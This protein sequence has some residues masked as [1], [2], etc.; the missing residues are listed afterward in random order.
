V[1]VARAR[2]TGGQDLATWNAGSPS[3]LEASEIRKLAYFCRV[4]GCPLYVVHLNS[5]QGLDAVRQARAEGTRIIAETCPQYLVHSFAEE[6]DNVLLKHTPPLR[7]P[8][9]SQALWAALAAGEIQ[10]I[11]T[12][13]IPN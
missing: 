3:I 9:D 1:L 12:D 11:G 10:C 2:A 7:S 8:A 4:L 13:H 6:P 5:R